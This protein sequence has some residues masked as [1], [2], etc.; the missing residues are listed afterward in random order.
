MRAWTLLMT[1]RKSHNAASKGHITDDVTGPYDDVIL[2]T[3]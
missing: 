1:Y 2:K 3:S